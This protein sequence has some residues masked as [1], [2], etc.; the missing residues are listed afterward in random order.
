MKRAYSPKEIQSMNI[1]CFPFTDEWEAAFGRP[2]RT[3]TGSFGA[4]AV[5]VKVALLCSWQSIYA[6]SIR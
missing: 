6:S 4:I 1:P 5:T 2:D 3:G